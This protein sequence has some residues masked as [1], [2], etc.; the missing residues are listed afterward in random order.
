[1][2]GGASQNLQNQLNLGKV[3]QN[4]P[5]FEIFAKAFLQDLENELTSTVRLWIFPYYRV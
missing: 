5:N 3:Q 4:Q 2:L 1:M